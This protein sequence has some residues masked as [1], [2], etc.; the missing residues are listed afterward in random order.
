MK[1]TDKKFN[2][3]LKNEKVNHELDEN[4]E[5]GIRNVKS[6]KIPQILQ[7]PPAYNQGALITQ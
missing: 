4:Q 7:G 2:N 3:S 5:T 1:R 6:I